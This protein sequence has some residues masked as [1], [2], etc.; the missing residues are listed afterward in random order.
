MGEVLVEFEELVLAPDGTAYYACACGGRAG[1]RTRQ[2]HGWIEF[3]PVQGGPLIRTPRE[4]TQP[5]KANTARWASGLTPVYLEGAIERALRW[6]LIAVE[7]SSPLTA[8][9]DEL[10]RKAIDSSARKPHTRTREPAGKPV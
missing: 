1:D 3:T 4:T 10:S 2:W 7:P 8:A 5:D 6:G 9:S